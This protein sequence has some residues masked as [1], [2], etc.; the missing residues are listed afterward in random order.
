MGMLHN[1]NYLVIHFRMVLH[2]SIAFCALL[3]GC[4]GLL[5]FPLKSLGLVWFLFF[6]TV[7]CSKK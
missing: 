1:L 6:K 4:S 2:F 7:F 3:S 5:A